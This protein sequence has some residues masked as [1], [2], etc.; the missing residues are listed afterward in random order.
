MKM[1]LE[2]FVEESSAEA[3][4]MNLLPRILGPEH[5]FRIHAHQGK[6]DLL[7]SLHARLRGYARW[8]PEDWKIVVVTDK[9]R[10]GCMALKNRL[11]E[12]AQS[13]GLVTKTS[14]GG[15]P[16]SVLNR[17]AIEE[18]EAWYFGDVPAVRQVFPRIPS[19]LDR[20]APFRDPDAIGGGTWEA[21]ERILQRAGY[22]PGGMPKVEVARAISS[23]MNV[24]VNRS[25]SFQ[26]FRDGL[27]AC[28]L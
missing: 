7:G 23:K 15:G 1:H 26:V 9:D 12:M 4:F 14:A 8:L 3:A 22:F 21:L 6:A 17:I 5:E 19:T 10:A 27:M 20:K 2:V 25:R 13:A 11:E 28:L 16:F 24:H 18:L